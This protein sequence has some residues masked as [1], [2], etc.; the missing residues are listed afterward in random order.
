MIK[1]SAAYAKYGLERTSQLANP[2]V[3]SLTEFELPEDSTYHHNDLGGVLLGPRSDNPFLRKS[4][5]RL[6]IIHEN[7]LLSKEGNPTPNKANT[8]AKMEADFRRTHRRM[9]PIRN[10]DAALRMKNAV[11]IH[12]YDMLKN[13]YDYRSGRFK[14]YWR[15]NNIIF[16][17]Y[18]NMNKVMENNNRHQFMVIEVPKRIPT[19]RLMN[20]LKAPIESLHEK[21]RTLVSRP[22][23]M[24]LIDLWVWLSEQRSESML[25]EI[26]PKN[27]HKVTVVFTTGST[28]TM[29]NLDKLQD[30]LGT[31][32]DDDDSKEV[33]FVGNS[34]MQR[35]MYTFLMSLIDSAKESTNEQALK[36]LHVEDEAEPDTE[37]K[38]KHETTEAANLETI[39]DADEVETIVSVEEQIEDDDSDEER[40][41]LDAR[42]SADPKEAYLH[43][44]TA[45][46]MDGRISAAQ[47]NRAKKLA[48]R[49]N[50]LPSPYGDGLLV[51]H[52]HI[53]DED[54]NISD[55]DA[56][57]GY[58][59]RGVQDKSMLKSKI[60]VSTDRYINKIMTKDMA[61][62]VLDI[63]R[64]GY[65]IGKYDVKEV[66]G[67]GGDYMEA[68]MQVIPINGDTSTIKWRYPKVDKDGNF[69]ADGVKY[70]MKMQRGDLPIR[71]VG[72][73][74][75][76]LTSY[77]AKVFVSR[78]S[79]SVVNYPKSLEKLIDGAVDS[80]DLKLE[81]ARPIN[82]FLHEADVPRIYSVMARMYSDFKHNGVEYSFNHDVYGKFFEANDIKRTEQQ[83]LTLVGKGKG[84]LVAV[85]KD[86]V[87]YEIKKVGKDAYDKKLT[88]I[89]YVEDLLG[90]DSSKTNI[91]V[92][93]FQFYSKSVPVG[94]ALGYAM[95]IEKLLR[96]L[97]SNTR[98]VPTGSRLD[99]SADEYAIKFQDE[100]LVINKRD[101]LTSLIIGGF[102]R[103]HKEIKNYPLHAF[104]NRDVYMNIMED[105]GIRVGSMREMDL[106][107]ERFVDPI[108]RDILKSMGEPLSLDELLVRAC[109]L[110]MTDYHP[111]E[112]ARLSQREKGYERFAGHLYE[113]LSRAIRVHRSRGVGADNKLEMNPEALWMGILTDSSVGLVEEINPIRDLK[114][115]EEVTVSGTGG[116]SAR[117][118]V[119]RT[120][121]FTKEDMG[122]TSESTTDSS[123][124]GINFAVPPNPNLKNIR[125]IGNTF[126]YDNY[127]KSSVLSSSALLAPGVDHDDMKRIV[128][129]PIQHNHGVATVGAMPSPYATGYDTVMAHR[130][131]DLYAK[132]ATQDGK[133]V[134]AD[135]KY[136]VV[137]YKDGTEDRIEVGRRYG[138]V[139]DGYVPHD[140]VC[141]LKKGQ[142]FKAGDVLTYNEGYFERD[143]LNP[144]QVIWRM[145]VYGNTLL[146]EAPNT[147]ED[148]CEVSQ[149]FAHMFAT[150]TSA[151]R[152]IVVPFDND[153]I[154]MVKLGDK[155][156]SDS[157]LCKLRQSNAES[158]GV[159]GDNAEATLWKLSAN[160][161]TA[162]V[163]GYI[164]KIEVLYHG[165]IDDMSDSLKKM[166]RKSDKEMADHRKAL[167]QPIISGKIDDT[168]RIGAKPLDPNSAVIRVYMT[169]DLPAG[170]GDKGVIGNQGKTVISNV[171]VGTNVTENGDPIDIKFSWK[172][173]ANRMV[174]SPKIMG[175]M[176][177]LLF[178]M[179]DLA[180]EF[181]KTGKKGTNRPRNEVPK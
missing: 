4:E 162:K 77:H 108:T 3:G 100:T 38:E 49:T 107:M 106:A 81:N 88:T 16:T 62:V 84:K 39:D 177:T 176:N 2:R 136:V 165:E 173:F 124:V 149:K 86:N 79:R 11:I 36:D 58:D 146:I 150:K 75:V 90:L 110:L 29:V 132:A 122:L 73:D 116:R 15:W 129:V 94:I 143:P 72:P 61:R 138:R 65:S 43:K 31:N 174:E 35:K 175:G 127:D 54:I 144:T 12:N 34:T 26:K 180:Y 14:E 171:M 66:N 52:A 153:I 9:K 68:S 78:S 93:E 10:M 103:Y 137:K 126:D 105:N 25:S 130:T 115:K 87:F 166:A 135:E 169:K 117:S 112:N 101:T 59:V 5:S 131:S 28:F 99:L 102:N 19:I 42:I 8:P 6:N 24:A 158:A 133:V 128:F 83:G 123:T 181:W 156:A 74:K 154:D 71:K 40:A 20:H 13:G 178:L 89:G 163:A 142:S 145:G 111:P 44:A 147:Y 119:K 63:Q 92:A 48:E 76:A 125:G 80:G 96:L 30:L 45:M 1:Y 69:M 114:H 23:F 139:P 21:L 113:E 97:K 148:S 32:G 164:E 151:T 67:Y 95:G 70:R 98:R 82:V 120:R 160:M 57:F 118:M 109:E 91:E 161:P 60:D 121:S 56:E 159:Y 50:T 18:K 172:S 141:D 41:A 104:Q 47:L 168:M 17:Q 55:K 33:D 155:V 179:S 140:L 27:Y 134:S 53:T 37:V 46:A 7:K 64:S 85:D 51:D 22:K 167:G 157:I 152:D 170:E